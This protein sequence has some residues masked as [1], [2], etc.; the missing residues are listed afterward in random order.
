MEY[1]P[2]RALVS[3]A[4][5]GNR[6]RKHSRGG[7]ADLDRHRR[8][9]LGEH[10]QRD[11]DSGDLDPDVREVGTP[12]AAGVVE[13]RLRG[14]ALDQAGLTVVV[15]DERIGALQGERR[16]VGLDPATPRVPVRVPQRRWTRVDRQDAAA[17]RVPR[18]VVV[19]VLGVPV[20]HQHPVLVREEL[21]LLGSGELPTEVVRSSLQVLVVGDV[22]AVAGQV[23][24]AVAVAARGG[25]VAEADR[26]P[27]GRAV[28]G[29]VGE[30]LLSTRGD[31][32]VV[33]QES[34]RGGRIL[35]LDTGIGGVAETQVD[36]LTREG[37]QVEGRRAPSRDSARR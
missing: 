3:H 22:A 20:V 7:S 9:G 35:S 23:V 21:R 36:R 11:A 28:L 30:D 14:A 31:R 6:Q 8:T 12:I 2:C 1:S 34:R 13:Q 5:M 37:A 19:A 16:V 29:A 17:P 26:L 33:Q 32:D 4:C 18:R 27:T 10:S 25:D 15:Q 24:V